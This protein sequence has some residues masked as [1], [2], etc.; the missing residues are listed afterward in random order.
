MPTIFWRRHV[1]SKNIDSY[2]NHALR[3][4]RKTQTRE[5]QTGGYILKGKMYIFF[6]NKEQNA[7]RLWT[8]TNT[9]CRWTN[10]NSVQA[11][12]LT[13]KISGFYTLLSCRLCIMGRRE[14]SPFLWETALAANPGTISDNG[15]QSWDF[16]CRK[17]LNNQY[18][19]FLLLPVSLT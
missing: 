5:D 10:F 19:R 13:V 6:F 17:A 3:R 2:F 7:V 1:F 4:E 15:L 14:N 16:Y 8:D 18:D 9:H 11:V 12:F